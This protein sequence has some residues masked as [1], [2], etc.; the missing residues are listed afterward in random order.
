MLNFQ[1]PNTKLGEE[2]LR[3]EQAKH[4]GLGHGQYEKVKMYFQVAIGNIVS[5]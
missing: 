2:V 5:N 1:S 3:E 4:N